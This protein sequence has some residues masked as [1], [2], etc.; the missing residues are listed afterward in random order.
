[1]HVASWA[2]HSRGNKRPFGS[3]IL[4]VNDNSTLHH[5]R[6]LE[7]D[8][9]FFLFEKLMS[10]FAYFDSFLSSMTMNHQY[11]NDWQFMQLSHVI[12]KYDDAKG[13]V[14]L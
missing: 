1:M 14:C 4:Q 7:V 5:M 11:Y 2:D 8:I 12:R 6:I 9:F 10:W 13:I 3:D